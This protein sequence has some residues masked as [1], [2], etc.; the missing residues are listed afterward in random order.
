M[1]LSFERHMVVTMHVH[2]II[3][4]TIKY[5]RDVLLLFSNLKKVL[6][7]ISVFFD[8]AGQTITEKDFEYVI[9]KCDTQR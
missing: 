9:R 5:Y 3:V 7:N 6:F 4:I 8:I 1:F 2:S